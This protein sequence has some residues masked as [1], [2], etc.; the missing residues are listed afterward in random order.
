MSDSPHFAL[1]RP[2]LHESL[3]QGER[4]IACLMRSSARDYPAGHVLIEADTEH[5][6]VYRLVQGW[7]CRTRTLSDGRDQCILTFLPGD[8]FA[9]KSMFVLRHPDRVQLLSESLVERI[10][11][12]ELHDAYSRDADISNRCT[13]QVVEEE[14]RLHNWIVGL[15]QGNAAERIAMLLVDFHGRLAV[16]GAIA[17]D[18]LSFEMP[19]TQGQLADHVGITAIHV[20]RV[21]RSLRE[22]GVAI[23]RDG[24]VTILDLA[25][26]TQIAYPLL[27]AYERGS[28]SYVGTA[29]ESAGDGSNGAPQYPVH[30]P[31]R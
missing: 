28:S 6:Y 24:Q 13:W 10:H 29:E 21:L 15:G 1:H 11:Y 9:V 3:E 4:K 27:D 22:N 14:R 31:R 30:A 7:A 23:A 20:N 18:Q 5:A 25:K 26:L 16:S 12:R 8:L 2:E 19:L 17:R